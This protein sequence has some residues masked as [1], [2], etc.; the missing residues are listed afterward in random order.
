APYDFRDP[1]DS[2][3]RLLASIPVTIADLAV[4]SLVAPAG[5]TIGFSS[6]SV[7]WTVTNVGSGVAVG[8]QAANSWTDSVYLSSDLDVS[9]SPYDL[10]LGSVTHEGA[11]APGDSYDATLLYT[12]SFAFA[13]PQ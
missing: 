4:S 6:G 10:L 7:S 8:G 2:N 5:G 11:L 12:L 9:N 13:G 1:D 3:N